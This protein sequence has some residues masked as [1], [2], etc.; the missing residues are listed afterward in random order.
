MKFKLMPLLLLA[1]GSLF[2]QGYY[3]YYGDR[4][5]QRR[6]L[7]EDYRDLRHDYARLDRLRAD[8]ARDR[9]QLNAALARG[10]EWAATRIARDLAR[11]QRALRA[12]QADINRDH[13]D[14]HQDQRDLYWNSWRWR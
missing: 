12:L 10:D 9:Y 5:D 2:A 14:I 11:D 8:I 7:H 4:Y 6:D 13:H 3:G 1:G